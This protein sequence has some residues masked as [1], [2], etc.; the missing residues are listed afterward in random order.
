MTISFVSASLLLCFFTTHAIALTRTS[1]TYRITA[2]I[3]DAGGRRVDSATTVIDGSLGGFVGISGNGTGTHSVKHGFAGQ[4]YDLV[5]IEASAN[6]TSIVENATRQLDVTG[7][8][9]DDTRGELESNPAWLVLSGPLA[10]IDGSGRATAD[11]VYEDT[12]AEAGATFAGLT[13]TVALLI[14][15]TNPDDFGTYAGDGVHDD[16]QVGFFGVGDPDGGPDR[17]P[18][19]DRRDNRYEWIT[20]TD[21]TSDSSYFLMAIE[22]VPGEDD[23]QDLV[24]DPTFVDR[25]YEMESSTDPVSN[26]WELLGNFTETTNGT[27]LTVR[28][29]DATNR[30][31]LYRTKVTFSP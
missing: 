30:V 24:L 26:I 7:V 2:E 28:H 15:N 27:E 29:L 1:E 13:G 17:D 3:A 22:R 8:F 20:G 6:P 4:L 31:L 16:W 9:D 10:S 18:D 5:A 25:T 19:I 11:T 12:A 21:P 14:V 23:Q